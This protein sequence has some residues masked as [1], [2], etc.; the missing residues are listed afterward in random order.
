VSRPESTS[1]DS[2][3][4]HFADIVPILTSTVIECHR[5]GLKHAAFKYATMLMKPEY[6]RNVDVKYAK[7]IEAVV[8]KPP[9][10]GKDGEPAGDPAEP[11]SPCP[12]CENLLSETEVNCNSCKNN[13][14]FCIVTVT[15]L[16]CVCCAFVEF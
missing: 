15:I 14:P 8:R 12:Y 5:A 11:S 7:K 4:G 9:K 16:S 13:I 3:R 2:Y 6:R 10:S 1:Y